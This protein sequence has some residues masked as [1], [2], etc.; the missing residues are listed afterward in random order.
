MPLD[1]VQIRKETEDILAEARRL[2]YE[3]AERER[4]REPTRHVFAS[5]AACSFCK[6]YRRGLRIAVNQSVVGHLCHECQA[7]FNAKGEK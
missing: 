5:I 3:A 7:A 1:Y 2:Q 6:K 4:M